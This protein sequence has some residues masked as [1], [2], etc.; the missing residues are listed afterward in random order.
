MVHYSDLSPLCHFYERF[1]KI[2]Y[3]KIF[4]PRAM[5]LFTMGRERGGGKTDFLKKMVH[6][7]TANHYDSHT[8]G[9]VHATVQEK[10]VVSN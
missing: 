5:S 2:L 8:S 10:A 9:S 6:V 4:N 3:V 7:G 1:K